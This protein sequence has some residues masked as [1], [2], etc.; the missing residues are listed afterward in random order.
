[1]PNPKLGKRETIRKL[2]LAKRSGIPGLRLGKRT[3]MPELRLGKR[4]GMTPASLTFN[5]QFPFRSQ[6]K[7]LLTNR[8]F[9]EKIQRL[10]GQR[11]RLVDIHWIKNP[12]EWKRSGIPNLRLG[13]RTETSKWKRSGMPNLRLGKRFGAFLAAN[14]I[15]NS[16]LNNDGDD[17][18]MV[19]NDPETAE[20]IQQLMTDQT[21]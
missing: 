10:I 6:I 17:F 14:R 9:V 2:M 20:N 1:M 16:D 15:L 4:S 21:L 13:K 12:A 18:Q 19:L 5:K 3:A 8:N 7:K 11:G